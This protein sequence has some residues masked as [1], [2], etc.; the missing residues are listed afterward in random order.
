MTIA[1][2][3]AGEIRNFTAHP[4]EPQMPLDDEPRGGYEKGNRNH[5][6]RREWRGTV[7]RRRHDGERAL[8][9]RWVD[10]EGAKKK[11]DVR[12]CGRSNRFVQDTRSAQNCNDTVTDGGFA[13]GIEAKRLQ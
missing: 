6:G 5:R 10:H 12:H 4:D 11:V 8:Q 3:G 1:R 9:K 7:R 13:L 2:R